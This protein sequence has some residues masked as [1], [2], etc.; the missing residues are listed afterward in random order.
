MGRDHRRTMVTRLRFIAVFLS[1]ALPLATPGHIRSIY[2]PVADECKQTTVAVLSSQ[3][4][5]WPCC[6]CGDVQ[7][8]W[9][10]INS[11]KG[12]KFGLQVDRAAEPGDLI[13]VPLRIRAAQTVALGGTAAAVADSDDEQQPPGWGPLPTS[14]VVEDGGSLALS[15]LTV[16]GRVELQSGSVSLHLSGVTLSA[17]LS[18]LASTSVVVAEQVV[19]SAPIEA[20]AATLITITGSDLTGG[21]VT[22]GSQVQRVTLSQSTVSHW[23][24]WLAGFEMANTTESIDARSASQQYV[25]TSNPHP[26]LVIGPGLSLSSDCLCLQREHVRDRRCRGLQRGRYVRRCV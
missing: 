18:L 12:G 3:D 17:R 4:T 10:F 7:V 16:L 21:L 8:F 25:R 13:T 24:G 1:V 22:F 11:G 5:L 9:S 6:S 20:V 15:T 26:L 19:F 14:F 2:E 23:S